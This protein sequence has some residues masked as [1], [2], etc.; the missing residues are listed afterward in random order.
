[1]E[2]GFGRRSKTADSYPTQNCLYS[3]E[4]CDLESKFFIN[5][6]EILSKFMKNA[7]LLTI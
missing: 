5:F 2:A 1:M 3:N 7:Y 6:D 4:I